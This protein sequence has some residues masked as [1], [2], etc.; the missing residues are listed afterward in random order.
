MQTRSRSA[1]SKSNHSSEEGANP[2]SNP[3]PNANPITFGSKAQWSHEDEAA[4]LRVGTMSTP[5]TPIAPS[6]S[7]R[8]EISSI[9]STSSGLPKRRSLSNRSS[10]SS[11]KNNGLEDELLSVLTSIRNFLDHV[12]PSQATAAAA[13]VPAA[14]PI[15]AADPAP[16]SSP[17]GTA[18]NLFLRYVM[19]CKQ[20]GDE[21]LAPDD[22]INVVNILSGDRTAA[23]IYITL[24]SGFDESTMRKWVE[25]LIG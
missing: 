7:T 14:A 15:P 10:T 9:S 13:P 2:N 4:L 11:K 3:N 5:I 22:V 20:R 25:T 17:E 23:G 16:G 24:I 18:S 6:S 12:I 21:W 8:L 19:E 1:S